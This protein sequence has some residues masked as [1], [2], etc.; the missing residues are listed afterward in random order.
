MSQGSPSEPTLADVL[1]EVVATRQELKDLGIRLDSEVK[2]WDERFYKFAE[3][4]ANRANT[5][6]ASATIAV[7]AGT[8]LLI[9]REGS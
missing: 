4:T 9:L 2:R 1:A 8:L 7:I 3:D 5:L 6:I